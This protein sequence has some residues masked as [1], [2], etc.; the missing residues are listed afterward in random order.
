MK[1]EE[2]HPDQGVEARAIAST[3]LNLSYNANKWEAY[4]YSA[5]ELGVL[6]INE[7]GLKIGRR[8]SFDDNG[9]GYQ[10]L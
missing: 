8:F 5:I 10:G 6:K 2:R 1:R 7:E 9:G 3:A 4:S